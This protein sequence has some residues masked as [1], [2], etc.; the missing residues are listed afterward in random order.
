MN[1]LSELPSYFRN[2]KNVDLVSSRKVCEIKDFSDVIMPS[3]DTKI[4]EFNKYQNS[5]KLPFVFSA[6]FECFIEKTDGCKN[7]P[8]NTSSIFHQ[9]FQ[10]LQYHHLE[11]QK[12]SMMYKKLKIYENIL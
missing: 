1:L 4:L 6:G 10:C 8:E 11:A 3:K 7:N 2:R 9:V 12:I 5:D